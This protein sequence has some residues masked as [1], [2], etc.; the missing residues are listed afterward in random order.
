MQWCVNTYSWVHHKERAF[1]K[2]PPCPSFVLNS[3]N[4]DLVPTGAS[5]FSRKQ[6]DS[7]QHP[8]GCLPVKAHKYILIQE[9]RNCHINPCLYVAGWGI[10]KD[11]NLECVSGP[12]LER[13]NIFI[14]KVL[15]DALSIVG[16]VRLVCICENSIRPE[17]RKCKYV[18]NGHLGWVYL[19]KF[20]KCVHF[21]KRIFIFYTDCV[22]KL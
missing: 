19:S 12:V 21:F 2:I 4:T 20:Y 11:G 22:L 18:F 13:R 6:T 9:A 7:A 15:S 16:G 8:V 5:E 14:E 10:S 17:N 1:C 3:V